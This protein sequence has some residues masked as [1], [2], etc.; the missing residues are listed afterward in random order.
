MTDIHALIGDIYTAIV[1]T[2]QAAE[3]A[4]PITWRAIDHHLVTDHGVQIGEFATVGYARFAALNAPIY[5][6]RRCTTDRMTL[7]E[8]RKVFGDRDLSNYEPGQLHGDPDEA[9]LTLAI[10][11]VINMAASYD[12][13][14]ASRW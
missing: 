12:R 13:G 4:T 5:V 6:V 10:T 11:T 9:A 1:L 14:S 3:A 8:C 7:S 2:E